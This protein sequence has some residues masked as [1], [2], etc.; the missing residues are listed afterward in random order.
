MQPPLCFAVL[1]MISNKTA[2]PA[3]PRDVTMGWILDLSLLKNWSKQRKEAKRGLFMYF[4]Q[5]ATFEFIFIYLRLTVWPPSVCVCCASCMLS[6]HWQA[7][8][9][10]VT[11]CWRFFAELKV[12]KR[13]QRRPRRRRRGLL[14]PVSNRPPSST[15]S[16]RVPTRCRGLNYGGARTR[17]LASAGTRALWRIWNNYECSFHIVISLRA[18]RVFLFHS[19]TPNCL[20]I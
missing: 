1:N 7:N 4:P 14:A 13:R 12:W 20:C 9:G 19:N 11:A 15:R 17:C 10:L 3:T 2:H 8:T 6:K 16:R 18:H 5:A